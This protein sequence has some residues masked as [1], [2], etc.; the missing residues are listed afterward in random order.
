MLSNEQTS[1]DKGHHKSLNEL[2]K[3]ERWRCY[4]ENWHI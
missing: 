3:R 2:F 1:Q 4:L